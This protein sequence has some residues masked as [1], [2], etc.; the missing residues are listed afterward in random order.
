MMLYQAIDTLAQ[1]W[2]VLSGVIR[3]NTPD[4][5]NQ[6]GLLENQQDCSSG[7]PGSA[8]SALACLEK[9]NI[10]FLS[11]YKLANMITKR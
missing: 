11:K 2:A 1:G 6:G 9:V 7:G 4:P 3:R 5:D 8:T 10:K